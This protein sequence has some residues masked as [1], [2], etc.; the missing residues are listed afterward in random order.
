MNMKKMSLFLLMSFVSV[1][2][3]GNL[4]SMSLLQEIEI[5]FNKKDASEKERLE[6]CFDFLVNNE[7]HGFKDEND[8]NMDESSFDELKKDE[9][10]L[11]INA[12]ICMNNQLKML[13]EQLEKDDFNKKMYNQIIDILSLS[14]SYFE[15]EIERRAKDKQGDDTWW[16]KALS[17][18]ERVLLYFNFKELASEL[19]GLTLKLK[20]KS[21]SSEFESLFKEVLSIFKLRVTSAYFEY[22]LYG[23]GKLKNCGKSIAKKTKGKA[24]YLL[25]L[26]DALAQNQSLIMHPKKK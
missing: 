4:F 10:K 3:F 21:L 7:M 15:R 19:N 22:S 1:V 9:L 2:S 8:E 23:E 11:K 26:Y 16:E 12:V 13:H 17:Y 24:Q 25:R 5:F 20:V 18:W 6:K 14:P